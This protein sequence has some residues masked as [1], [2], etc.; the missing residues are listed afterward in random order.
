MKVYLIAYIKSNFGDD[1]FVKKIVEQYPDIEFYMNSEN[2]DFAKAFKNYKNMNIIL[3]KR[4]FEKININAYDAFIYVG[5]SIFVESVAGGQKRLEMFNDFILDCKRKNKPFFYVSSNF[6][7]YQTQEYYDSARELFSNCTDICF[8]DTYSS[9]LFKD[10]DTVRYA[11]DLVFSLK[12]NKEETLNDTV[13]V[14][15]VD[16]LGVKGLEHK[17]NEYYDFLENNI[18]RYIDEGKEVYLFSFCKYFGEERV[19]DTVVNRFSEEYIDKIK[20]VKYNGDIDEFLKIYSKMEYMICSKFHAMILSSM[21][22]QKKVVI[23]YL[24][25][26]NNVNNDLKLTNNIMDLQDIQSDMILGLSEFDMC[27]DKNIESYIKSSENQLGKINEFIVNYKEKLASD[28]ERE[29]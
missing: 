8:R 27:D 28:Y 4:D 18:K 6:G 29:V 3:E 9:N 11:P 24:S 25:K 19:I 20:V 15:V 14:S 16:V 1:L 2:E 21:F 13:G 7:P 17:E 22:N 12:T 26:L 10:L 23:S 5:G